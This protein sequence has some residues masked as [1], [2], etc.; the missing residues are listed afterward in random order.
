MK[1]P[2]VFADWLLENPPPSLG[3]MIEKYGSFI[4][5]PDDIMDQFYKDCEE[6]RDRL[7]HRDM[8]RRG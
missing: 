4:D 7:R 1:R 3:E 8:D 6:W 5:I 2:L